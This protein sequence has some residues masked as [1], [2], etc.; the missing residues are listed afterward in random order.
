MIHNELARFTEVQR[1]AKVAF[2]LD[3]G[4]GGLERLSETLQLVKDF[5]RYPE[6]AYL[7]GAR[8]V[9]GGDVIAAGGAGNYSAIACSMQLDGWIAT[10]VGAM[11]CVPVG[12]AIYVKRGLPLP[13]TSANRAFRDMRITGSPVGRISYVNNVAAVPGGTI[14]W[15][16]RALAN[17]PLWIPLDCVLVNGGPVATET[18]VVVYADT[19]NQAFYGSF[20]WVERQLLPGELYK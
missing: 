9:M 3:S 4:A 19:A 6:D 13:N 20:L 10:L 15:L 16:T 5:W 7:R 2:G 18:A 8:L 11:V 17:D 12:S 1:G 14:C